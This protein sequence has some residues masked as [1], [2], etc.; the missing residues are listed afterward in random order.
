MVGYSA[1]HLVVS[2]RYKLLRTEQDRKA[3]V[4]DRDMNSLMGYILGISCNLSNP[5]LNQNEVIF[6]LF[7]RFIHII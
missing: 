6:Y 5:P 3:K 1:G 2:S 7:L 4:F